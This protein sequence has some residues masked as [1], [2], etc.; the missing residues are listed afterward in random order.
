MTTITNVPQD[1]IGAYIASRLSVADLRDLMKSTRHLR[2]ACRLDSAWKITVKEL[3][4]KKQGTNYETVKN[5]H[6]RFNAFSDKFLPKS[7]E[8]ILTRIFG[9]VKSLFINE[10]KTIFEANIQRWKDQ[11]LPLCPDVRGNI[12]NTDDIIV[13]IEIAFQLYTIDPKSN[14]KNYFCAEA[15]E[16]GY[17]KPLRADNLA[18]L[19]EL[20][21][22][23]KSF[24]VQFADGCYRLAADKARRCFFY[25]NEYDKAMAIL[26][27]NFPEIEE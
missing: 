3:F 21:K 4:L 6:I 22:F 23:P 11:N 25:R 8:G 2:A 14:F 19:N 20:L 7:S 13:P 18:T 16:K 26:A 9:G 12:N 5:F 24:S 27:E 10:K 17:L 1:V 15:L